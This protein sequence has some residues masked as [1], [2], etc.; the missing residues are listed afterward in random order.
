MRVCLGVNYLV[1][2]VNS[3]CLHAKYPEI[4]NGFVGVILESHGSVSATPRTQLF[5]LEDA[6]E[7]LQDLDAEAA[8]MGTYRDALLAFGEFFG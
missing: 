5:E 6:A 2:D 1:T 8:T 7:F 4:Y 3:I